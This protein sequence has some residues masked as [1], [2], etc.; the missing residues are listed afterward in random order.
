MKL[1]VSRT[2]IILPALINL[3]LRECE[4]DDLEKD[5]IFRA[6]NGGLRLSKPFFE[7]II[8]SMQAKNLLQIYA[9]NAGS[10]RI[11]V[12]L[13]NMKA[14]EAQ[15]GFNKISEQEAS[16]ELGVSVAEV[17][18]FFTAR[19]VD[20]DAITANDDIVTTSGEPLT[21]PASDRVVSLDHNSKVYKEAV[22]SLEN[23]ESEL[24]KS[25][26]L[27]MKAEERDAFVAEAKS[28]KLLI[29]GKQ[30]RQAAIYAL[31]QAR[32]FLNKLWTKF[33]TET[34]SVL[35]LAAIAA[36]KALVGL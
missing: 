15:V 18:N 2:E 1:S 10:Q 8:A 14:L 12:S 9:E 23:I 22:I 4:L 28:A 32:G 27:G 29:S 17:L 24:L 20:F 19:G 35:A 6:L 13:D 36:L 26:S 31:V 33:R 5:R 25:N 30:V 11:R 16:A 34:I 7:G 3:I 21:I